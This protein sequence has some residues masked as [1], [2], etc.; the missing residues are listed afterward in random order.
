[1][2]STRSRSGGVRR[3]RSRHVRPGARSDPH[4]RILHRVPLLDRGGRSVRPLR[5]LQDAGRREHGHGRR[6]QAVLRRRRHRHSRHRQCVAP[7]Q[8]DRARAAASRTASSEIVEV[9]IGYDGIVLANSKKH[10]RFDLTKEQIFLRAREAGA[11]RRQARPEPVQAL[12]RHRPVA[13]QAT[14][15]RCSVRRRPPARA[16]RSSSSRSRAAPKAFP[17]LDGAQ[18]QGREGLQGGRARDSRGRRLCRGRRERQPDR[19]EARGEPER[20]RRLRLLVPRGERGQD[21]GQPDRGRRADL[22][23]HRRAASTASR[24]RSTST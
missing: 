23:E 3:R 8:A 5:W 16:T 1:M 13:A 22:R 9:K 19:A 10:A 15:S 2:K 12:E 7:D 11:D 18:G 17:M 4:R 6:P 20:D 21:P 24:A 14:R